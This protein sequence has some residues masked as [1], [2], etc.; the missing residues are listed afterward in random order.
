MD[1]GPLSPVKAVDSVRDVAQPRDFQLRRRVQLLRTINRPV[2]ALIGVV[3]SVGLTAM[4]G[5]AANASEEHVDGVA[6]A[7]QV[8]ASGNPGAAYAALT[9]YEQAKFSEAV[10]PASVETTNM[11]GSKFVA[12]TA[13]S[14]AGAEAGTCW[15]NT[16]RDEVRSTAGILLFTF[17]GTAKWCWNGST[18]TSGSFIDQGGQAIF[19]GW[20]Y[21]GVNGKGSAIVANKAQMYVGL[22]F[23]LG[24]NGWDIQSPTYCIHVTGIPQGISSSPKCGI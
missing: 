13:E 20:R 3:L 12:P 22:K 11:D 1:L 4:G 8:F 23:I 15:S 9:S 21:A 18:V 6:I 7:E 14:M 17:W 5:M 19:I 2:K 24:A 10:T 16:L